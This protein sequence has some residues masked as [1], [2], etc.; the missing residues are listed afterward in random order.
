MKNFSSEEILGPVTLFNQFLEFCI[1]DYCR[2]ANWILSQEFIEKNVAWIE[3]PCPSDADRQQCFDQFQQACTSFL[4]TVYDW[5]PF[6][7][8]FSVAWAE[9]GPTGAQWVSAI[10]MIH[11]I[12]AKAFN[13]YAFGRKPKKLGL[14][15]S[16]TLPV[17]YF[18]NTLW[19]DSAESIVRGAGNDPVSEN[20]HVFSTRNTLFLD[21][22]Q[23]RDNALIKNIGAFMI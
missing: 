17:A 20:M 16:R 19:Q 15:I 11:P 21:K 10:S 5:Q 7:C 8:D 23:Y 3:F 2:D 22:P 6:G 13:K 14:D 9:T 1:S 4:D 12:Q 18:Q